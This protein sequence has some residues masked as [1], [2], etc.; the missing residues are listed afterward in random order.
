L[1]DLRSLAVACVK[2]VD[3]GVH[4]PP[5]VRVPMGLLYPERRILSTVPEAAGIL[6]FEPCADGPKCPRT[7]AAEPKLGGAHALSVG[8]VGSLGTGIDQ[9]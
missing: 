5:G 1:G 8:S 4:H 6:R 7:P 2:L 9:M 3:V